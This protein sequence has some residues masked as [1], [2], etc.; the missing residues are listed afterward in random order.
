MADDAARAD[1]SAAIEAA[2]SELRQVSLSI[3]ANPELGF[4]ERHAHEVL[5][6]LLDAH[7]FAV[8][9]SAYGVETAFKAVAGNG[10]PVMAVLCEYDALPGIG[11]ACGHNLIAISGIAT[12]LGLQAVLGEGN[13][14]VVVL[15]TPAEEG[16]GGKIALADAGA[17]EGVDAAL[18]LHPAPLA[19]A[20]GGEA[21]GLAGPV[22][23]L[24]RPLMTATQGLAV[25]FYG[26]PA[27]AAASP[28]DGLNA[29]DALVAGY[30]AVAMLRQHIRPDQRIHG[31]ITEGGTATNVVPEH[32]QARFGI[33]GRDRAAVDEL[34]VR[35]LACFEGAA[36]STGC[37]LE[38]RWGASG[39]DD[40]RTNG[41]MAD[42]FV[43]NAATL[44]STFA[45]APTN[46]YASTDMGNV[47]YL[48]PSIHPMFG[49]P[50]QFANHHPGFTEAAAS[51]EAHERTLTAAKALCHTALDLYG[52]ADLLAA[53]KQEFGETV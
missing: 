43:A 7:G 30:S 3:H 32:T 51:E 53:A 15:G 11:H 18:M 20:G 19:R 46:A 48:V 52:D 4:E 10:G 24:V 26:R 36:Q 44:G 9:R 25:D 47:S 42:A 37:R 13:G 29:L 2:S 38:Y 35:V 31:I 39:Y 45:T 21:S 28:W 41:R 5:T 12:G 22:D 14:T 50:A 17:F 16:G 49:I 34:R 40:L 6:D 1:A 8:E 27:H 33:R 23:G